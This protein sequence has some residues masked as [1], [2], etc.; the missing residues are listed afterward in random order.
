MQ[1][2]LSSDA[3]LGYLTGT[4]NVDVAD[5]GE[6]THLFSTGRVDSF[7]MIDLITYIEA[8]TGASI[9][10]GDITLDNFDSVGRIVNYVA[11][12]GT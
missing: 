10:P 2:G 1:M 8:E 4:L 6:D 7:S 5:L 11:S 9:P 3:I 12:R